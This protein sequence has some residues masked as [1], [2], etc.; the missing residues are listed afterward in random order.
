VKT[1]T[2]DYETYKKELED[3]YSKG[4]H[5]GSEALKSANDLFTRIVNRNQMA[6]EYGKQVSDNDIAQWIHKYG[7]L[8]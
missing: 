1:V 5:N 8:T 7:H 6:Y 4:F 3:E 2:L